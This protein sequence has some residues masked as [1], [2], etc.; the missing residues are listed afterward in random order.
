M[1]QTRLAILEGYSSKM[2]IRICTEEML[3]LANSTVGYS[4]ADLE[5]LCREAA[6]ICLREDIKNTVV[7]I[8]EVLYYAA[9]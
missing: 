9:S 7:N 3:Q 2:P 5:N 8:M 1:V 6:L 4:G